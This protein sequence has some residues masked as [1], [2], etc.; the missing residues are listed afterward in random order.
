MN[1][2]FAISFTPA[3]ILAE[4]SPCAVGDDAGHAYGSRYTNFDA[5][6]FPSAAGFDWHPR[7]TAL[8]NRERQA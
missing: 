4:S 1:E 7:T 5:G 8:R 3:E 2:F 6:G